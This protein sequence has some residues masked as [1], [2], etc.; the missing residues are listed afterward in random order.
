[1]LPSFSLVPDAGGALTVRVRPPRGFRP[2]KTIYSAGFLNWTTI[3]EGHSASS[4]RGL[5]YESKV[6]D[7]LE[8]LYGH[9]FMPNPWLWFDT[10]S[11]MRRCQPDG[12]IFLRD[13][14]AIVEVKL[15]HV[16]DAWW[17][18]RRLYEPVVK[19][20]FPSRRLTLIEVCRYFDPF[21]MMPE[22]IGMLQSLPEIATEERSEPIKGL[23]WK[24]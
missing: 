18:L 8:A 7:A 13:R 20:I 15:T 4:K 22:H 11:G 12:L 5:R 24:P 14:V 10:P 23:I 16:P 1:M 9:Q 21:V 2:A 6:F 19:R 3:N 17:Q